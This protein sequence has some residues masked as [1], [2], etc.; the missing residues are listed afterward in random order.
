MNW[1]GVRKGAGRPT[2]QGKFGAKT[3]PIRIPENMIDNVLEYINSKGFELPLYA[4]NVSAG[5]PSPADE[6]VEG[7]LDLNT[8]LIKNPPATFLVRANG[9]SMIGAGIYS[10]DVLV[11]DR[12]ID[13]KDGKIVI[14]AID[15]HLTVK[16]LSKKEGRIILKAENPKHQDI[17]LEENNDLII[18]GVVTS[19][20]HKV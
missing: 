3:K 17:I 19:V 18:W 10:G 8:Y 16:R 9:D 1:G 14:A 5:F 4:S 12:S 7:K 13:P 20:L 11:V 15:G 2:G 6:Y